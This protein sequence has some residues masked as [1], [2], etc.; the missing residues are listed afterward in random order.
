[1]SSIPTIGI[2]FDNTIVCYDDAVRELA[3]RDFKVSDVCTNKLAIRQYLRDNRGEEIWISFQGS[4]YGPGM[5]YARPYSGC[6]DALNNLAD[7]GIHLSIISH[8]TK[9]PY[10]GD[11]FDLHASATEWISNH[12]NVHLFDSGSTRDIY[13]LETKQDKVAKIHE[14]DCDLF[15]DDL[16]ELLEMPTFPATT[17]GILFDPYKKYIS[18]SHHNPTVVYSWSEVVATASTVFEQ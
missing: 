7:K 5:R 11:L 8:R 18:N 6:I 9:R 14:L 15:I 4:L 12:L 13:F 10:S 17:K 16:I 1:M 3:I 2:D